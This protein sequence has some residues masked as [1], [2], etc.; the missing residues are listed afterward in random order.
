M[1]FAN[2]T[3][4]WYL[5][6]F[7]F[8][9]SLI[10]FLYIVSKGFAGQYVKVAHKRINI[11]LFLITALLIFVKGFGTTGRDL[12]SGYYYNFMSANSL[13]SVYDQSLE[14]GYKLLNV[15]I[16]NVTDNYF[17]LI[18]IIST[19]TIIPV[20]KLLRK[21]KDEIDV[22]LTILLY[23]SIFFFTSFSPLRNYL[24]ASISLFAF[25]AMKENKMK[26]AL[27]WIVV[28]V[29]LHSSLII[30]FIPFVLYFMKMFNKKLI[31]FVLGIF[32]ILI[33]V[34]KNSIL[35][36]FLEAERYSKYS[37]VENTGFGLEQIVYFAPFFFL[38]YRMRRY[39]NKNIERLSLAYVGTSFTFGMLSY[40]IT[41]FG[42]AQADFLPII[43]IAGYYL[44]L[45]KT[46]KPKYRA[47]VTL[48]TLL[49]CGLRFW[50][51]ISQYYNL[52]DLMPYT[53][54]FGWEI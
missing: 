21:Y 46:K 9:T 7:I 44:R 4:D 6:T 18:F 23:L 19:L 54:V 34:G 35:G 50:L 22:P 3:V 52:E 53:N 37:D 28:S 16:R 14:F 42:R 33:I 29:L 12:R 41:V 25:D 10:L 17:V 40:V 39:A 45:I 5:S 32:F 30:I 31:A 15:I 43:F 38:I 49:Y 8:Y 24:A 1:P 27:I 20:V 51:Y 48:L 2:V 13:E 47:I 26:K 36:F 11:S